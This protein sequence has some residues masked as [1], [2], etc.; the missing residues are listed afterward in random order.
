MLL[1][2]SISVLVLGLHDHHSKKGMNQK[3]KLSGWVC[4]KGIATS[5]STAADGRPLPLE[6]LRKDQVRMDP[7]K[8]KRKAGARDRPFPES[9]HLYKKE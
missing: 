1:A 2:G 7:G 4:D 9:D 3:Q 6:S 8:G 5:C